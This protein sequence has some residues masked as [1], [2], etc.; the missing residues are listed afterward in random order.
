M[1]RDSIRD[2]AGLRAEVKAHGWNVKPTGRILVQLA[3]H[4]GVTVAGLAMLLLTEDL[5]LQGLAIVIAVL[6]TTG[7][8]TNTHSSAHAAPLRSQKASYG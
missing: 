1:D 3:Y 2:L 6:G 7:V 8:S 5:R 4:V